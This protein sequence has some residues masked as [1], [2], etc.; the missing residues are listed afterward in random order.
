MLGPAQRQGE[1]SRAHAARIARRA[2]A[3][4]RRRIEPPRGGGE[5]AEAAEKYEKNDALP[6]PAEAESLRKRVYSFV[7]FRLIDTPLP[8]YTSR[9]FENLRV[10]KK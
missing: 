9:D 10:S 8:T 1:H 6:T 5:I 2:T 3:R 4:Q 7:K